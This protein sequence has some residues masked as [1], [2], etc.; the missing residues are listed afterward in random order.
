MHT[1]MRALD[2]REFEH[3]LTDVVTG[4]IDRQLRERTDMLDA[5]KTQMSK[6]LREFEDLTWHASAKRSWM[7][8]VGKVSK[9]IAP[10]PTAVAVH[11]VVTSGNLVPPAVTVSKLPKCA[12]VVSALCV[13]HVRRLTSCVA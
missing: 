4:E 8:S 9:D 7:K 12:A 11:P 13:H 10:T 2:A 1:H 6:V 5:M 3:E